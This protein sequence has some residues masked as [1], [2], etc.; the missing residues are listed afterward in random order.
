MKKSEIIERVNE[1]VHERENLN[2]ERVDLMK[3]EELLVNQLMAISKELE[4]MEED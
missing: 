3:R 4:N 1:L 2:K